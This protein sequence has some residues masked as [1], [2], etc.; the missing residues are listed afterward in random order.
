MAQEIER[1]FLVDKVPKNLV[2]HPYI[3]IDQGYL[4]LPENHITSQEL[5]IRKSIFKDGRDEFFLAIKS[6]GGLSRDEAQIE[7]PYEAYIALFS[8]T[9][10]RRVAKTRYLI[11]YAH[12]EIEL[13]VYVG[14]LE[15]LV[16]AEV[17]FDGVEDSRAFVPPAWFGKEVTEDKSY[18]N[19]NLAVKKPKE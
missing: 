14:H 15:G 6:E 8:L 2:V 18:K 19:K 10:G 4:D 13:D 3:L 5:R 9:E 7:I 11:P 17:E 12:K 1:K 16:V